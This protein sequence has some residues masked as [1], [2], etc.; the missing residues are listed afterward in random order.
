MGSKLRQTQDAQKAAFEQKLKERLAFL[1]ARGIEGRTL[2]KDVIVRNLRASINAIRKRLAAID[3]TEKKTAD[4]ARAKA[5]K[6]AA[7]KKEAATKEE[8][9]AEAPK[10]KKE[11]KAKAAPA[12]GGEKKEKKKKE[13][14]EAE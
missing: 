6:A 11:K 5:E 12:E 9:A 10:E 13:K 2:D 8:K 7:P 1:G 4:L 14:P 3:A